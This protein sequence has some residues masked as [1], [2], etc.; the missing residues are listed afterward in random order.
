MLADGSAVGVGDRVVTRRNDRALITRG[1]WV[2][3]GDRWTVLD[4]SGDGS[5][6]VQRQRGAGIAW[7]PY[8][9]VHVELGY[10]IT[11]CRAQGISVDSAHYVVTG[12]VRCQVS[13]NASP[14]PRPVPTWRAR[15]LGRS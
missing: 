11:A 7:L 9:A 15:Y 5:L 1:G 8:V 14:R 3:N 4:S 2:K 12:G 10:A 6:I 13:I